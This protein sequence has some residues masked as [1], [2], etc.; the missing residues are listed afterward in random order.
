[1]CA[2]TIR[3]NTDEYNAIPGHDIATDVVFT[4]VQGHIIV[5]MNPMPWHA[6]MPYSPC[7]RNDYVPGHATAM[8]T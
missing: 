3:C 7:S 6:V 2:H 8:A 5:Y 1:M 4:H